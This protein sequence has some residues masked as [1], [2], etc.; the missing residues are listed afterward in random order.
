MK[1]KRNILA[2]F[3]MMMLGTVS[4]LAQV[5]VSGTV[6]EGATGE[7]VIGA[8]IIEEG[9]TNGTITDFDGNFSL[10]V[11]EGAQLVISYVGFQAQTLPAAANMSV[12]MA[13]DSELLEEVVVTGYTAQ[14]KADLTGVS[15]NKAA[16]QLSS[17]AVVLLEVR[18]LRLRVSPPDVQACEYAHEDI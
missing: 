11:S 5:Q 16:G 9:T 12:R 15:I 13:E 18:E 14:R 7:P 10:T 6:T 8:S 1:R 17:A 4:M 3:L 2:T